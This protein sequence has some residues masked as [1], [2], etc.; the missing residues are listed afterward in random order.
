MTWA[1]TEAISQ[2]AI[3]G[4]SSVYADTKIIPSISVSERYDSNVFMAPS[5]FIPS[6]RQRWDFVTSLVPQVQVLNKDRQVTV[7]INAGVSGNA[8]V[9]N[10]ELNFVTTN[11]GGVVN[12]DGWI[13]QFVK[14]AKLQVADTFAYTP[15]P[16]AFLTGVKPS[17]TGDVF[18][19]GIQAFRANTYTNLATLDG[20]YALSR[21]IT[22]AGRYTNS[23]FRVGQVFAEQAQTGVVP[24]AFFNTMFQ[25]WSAGPKV[26]VTRSDTMNLQYQGTR[27]NSSGAGTSQ[28]FAAQGVALE[29]IKATPSWTTTISGGATMLEQRNVAFFSGQLSFTGYY[30]PSTPV[31]VSISRQIAPA[32]FGTGGA[33]ISTAAS[34]AIERRLSKVLTFAGNANYGVNEA[35]PEK[36]F[37][38]HSFVGSVGIKYA[39]TRTITAELSYSYT[40]FTINAPAGIELLTDRSFVMFALMAK[41]Y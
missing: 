22:L 14:G 19:R 18:L 30:D 13:G 21:R 17:V 20:E 37:T 1:T 16:P 7:D 40:H 8:F 23:L 27:S 28:S 34:A 12:L 26:R 38:F 9:Y 15:E 33:I 41:W 2:Q 32:Y 24:I 5:Q 3:P 25:T 35:T 11:A 29:Y 36:R 10:P 4:K 39:M 31:R 6:G